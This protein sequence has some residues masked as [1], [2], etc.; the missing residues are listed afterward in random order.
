MICWDIKN[1]V[2][3]DVAHA[4]PDFELLAYAIVFAQFENGGQEWD[5]DR[6]QFI[7]KR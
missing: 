7:G 2:P 3:F 5:W 6:M 1:G 4:L